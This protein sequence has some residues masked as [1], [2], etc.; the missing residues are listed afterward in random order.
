VSILQSRLFPTITDTKLFVLTWI[1]LSS[2]STNKEPKMSMHADIIKRY[3]LSQKQ[4]AIKLQI[5]DI[6][7]IYYTLGEAV[8]DLFFEE[9]HAHEQAQIK[10]AEKEE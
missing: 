5:A 1:N 10:K 4:A 9:I 3:K 6:D 7:K 2:K 8:K